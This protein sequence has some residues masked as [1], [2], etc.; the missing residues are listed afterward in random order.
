MPVIP[1]TDA[2]SDSY[3]FRWEPTQPVVANLSRPS[4]ACN[5][6]PV[7]VA[8]IVLCNFISSKRYCNKYHFRTV[9]GLRLVLRKGAGAGFSRQV[10][11]GD[12]TDLKPPP[13]GLFLSKLCTL[14]SLK[15]KAL[16]FESVLTWS[17]HS[18]EID[19]FSVTLDQPIR[20]D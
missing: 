4:D 18:S 17:S 2:A 13:L 1:F 9:S 11:L 14:P 10:L 5:R 20:K 16:P 19:C 15:A 12:W 7:V 8:C 6:P 3:L